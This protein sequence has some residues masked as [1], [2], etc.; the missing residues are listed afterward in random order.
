MDAQYDEEDG[1]DWDWVS[2]EEEL[3][4]EQ[5][6][7]ET[8]PEIDDV[9]IDIA[10]DAF[11]GLD[12]EVGVEMRAM[13]FMFFV[14]ELA[15]EE[16]GLLRLRAQEAGADVE[17][18]ALQRLDFRSAL[19]EIAR[20]D[21]LHDD[22][23]AGEDSDGD[24]VGDRSSAGA[25]GNDN[26]DNGISDVQASADNDTSTSTGDIATASTST[27]EPAAA[28]TTES[29]IKPY[30]PTP[31]LRTAFLT[32]YRLL[33]VQ[34]EMR[35]TPDG[36]RARELYSRYQGYWLDLERAL[37]Q[38]TPEWRESEM[39]RAALELC[40][41]EHARVAR[42]LGQI[43]GMRTRA[44]VRRAMRNLEARGAERQ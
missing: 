1:F 5:P 36:H 41:M 37:P 40:R 7:N 15:T 3:W 30:L 12:D 11:H 25:A 44:R 22:S 18:L 24:E 26:P 43:A 35:P 28:P 27:T 31:A 6:G 21:N 20:D 8:V 38:L 33:R 42:R 13:R 4:R 2:F 9:E 23:S 34:Y 39:V 10:S 29:E 17:A 19:W 32:F 14:V 16:R